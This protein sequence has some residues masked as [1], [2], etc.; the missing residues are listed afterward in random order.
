M[1]KTKRELDVD[2]EIRRNIVA[3]LRLKGWS[4]RE[5][6]PEIERRLGLQSLSTGTI[7]A[8]MRK[9]RKEW[10]D[11]RIAETDAVITEELAKIDMVIREAWQQY[12]LSKLP[13][14]AISEKQAGVPIVKGED[15]K[16]GIT[17]TYIERL[18]KTNPGRGDVRYLDTILR[19]LERRQRLLGLDRVAVEMSGAV[20]ADVTISHVASGYTPASSEAEVREREGIEI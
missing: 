5:M 14:T 18:K 11:E 8:D 4:Y 9:L 7:S 6:V 1:G 3:E 19:A 16:P 17:P 15:E 12:E 13:A 10:R 20:Q 2:R